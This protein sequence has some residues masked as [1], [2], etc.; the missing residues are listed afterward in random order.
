MK[1]NRNALL[2]ALNAVN[3]GVATKEAL[4]QSASFVF[5]ED[6]RV[7]T[8]NDDIAVSHPVE[9]NFTGAVP[10]KE[11]LALIGK[12]KGAEIE[13]SVSEGEL[14][15]V[16]S[17]AK[18]GLR[19]EAE[20]HLPLDELGLPDQWEP[21]PSNF[22]PAVK[23]CLF[24]AGRDANKAALTHIH[25][26]E[27]CVESCD[28]DR[29]TRYFTS[30]DV[31]MRELMIPAQ[32]AR[33]LIGY[34]CDE[35]ATTD[36]WLHFRNAQDVTFSCRTTEESYP[37][38]DRF[39]ECKGG[40]GEFPE[41]LGE[42]LDRA[43]TL[44]DGERVNVALNGSKLT[45]STEGVAGWYEEPARVKYTGKAVDFD[46]HPDFLVSM[47]KIGTSIVIAEG[48][49]LFQTDDFVHIVKTYAPKEG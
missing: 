48:R 8:F 39:L 49:L 3:P 12:L 36:G 6:G 22:L 35:Y 46:I 18:A 7:C 30:E 27:D 34:G 21:L 44:S 14:R 13:L 5:T 47:L 38:L 1:I 17:K 33:H 32:A 42:M 10:A 16:G 26:L 25:V 43:N 20:I 45:V 40:K 19:L 4:Q 37:N 31:A 24:S 28:N 11:F 29:A 23:F 2:T 15:V 9:V 41:E